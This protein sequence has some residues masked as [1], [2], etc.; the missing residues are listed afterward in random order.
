MHKIYISQWDFCATLSLSSTLQNIN[1]TIKELLIKIY[2]DQWVKNTNT[3][4]KQRHDNLQARFLHTT[5]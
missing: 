3:L 2:T 5:R 4:L 1:N